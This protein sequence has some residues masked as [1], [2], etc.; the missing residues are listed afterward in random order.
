MVEQNDI[1]CHLLDLSALQ[2][3]R[4]LRRADQQAKDECGYRS[5][6]SGAQPD[7]ILCIRTEMMLRQG[8]AEKRAKQDT[9]CHARKRDTGQRDCTHDFTTLVRP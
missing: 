9:A 8:V 3:V 2:V 5:D 6:E 7:H 4:T 1:G